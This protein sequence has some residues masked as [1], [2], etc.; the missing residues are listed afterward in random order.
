LFE[1]FFKPKKSNQNVG[2]KM[3]GFFFKQKKSNKEKMPVY[4]S[5]ASGLFHQF[6]RRLVAKM[7]NFLSA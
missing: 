5:Q 3:F 2:E 1:I 6:K 4:P 7:V